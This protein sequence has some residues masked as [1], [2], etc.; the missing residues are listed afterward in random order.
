MIHD[1]LIRH[2]GS[3]PE[4]QL[5]AGFSLELRRRLETDHRSRRFTAALVVLRRWAPR[6]YWIA[7]LALML[8]VTRG[9]VFAPSR[10]VAMT[11]ASFLVLLV[12]QRALRSTP[13]TRILRDVLR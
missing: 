7:A 4:P 2:F 13:L 6:L 8:R 11:T 3:T 10:T 9:P 5:S 1:D 12:L